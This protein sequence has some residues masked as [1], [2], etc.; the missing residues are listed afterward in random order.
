MVRD[1][2]LGG[3]EANYPLQEGNRVL[4]SLAQRQALRALLAFSALHEQI[5][6]RSAFETGPDGDLFQTERFVLGEVLQL[7]CD[8]AQ[9]ITGAEGVLIALFEGSEIRIHAV[10]GL[11]LVDR[12]VPLVTESA[13]LQECL[14]SR[15]ILRC[16]DC[17]ADDRTE[18]DMCRLVGARSAVL[19][20]LRGQAA[21]VGVLQA[22]ARGPFAFSDDD[23]RCFDLFGELVLSALRPE[24][25][26]RRLNW[27]TDVASQLLTQ[28]TV[29]LEPEVVEPE[30]AAS[31]TQSAVAEPELTE[32]APQAATVISGLE[33]EVPDLA[34]IPPDLGA[35]LPEPV[36]ESQPSAIDTE[37]AVVEQEALVRED[38][39]QPECALVVE[40]PGIG[41]VDSEAEPADDFVPSFA[42]VGEL[43]ARTEIKLEPDE[44]ALFASVPSFAVHDQGRPWLR[45]ALVVVVVAGLFAAGA[46]WGIQTHAKAIVDAALPEKTAVETPTTTPTTAT[47]AAVVSDHLLDPVKFDSPAPLPAPA[48]EESLATFPKV[49]GVRHWTSAVGSTVAI[50]ME[51][52]VPYEV[53]RLSSPARIYFD[54]HDTALTPELVARTIDVGDSS[55][56]RVRVAQPVAG[57][58]RVVLDTKAGSDF[59]VSMEENPYRLIVQLR[60]SER[61]PVRT[62]LAAAPTRSPAK[63]AALSPVPPR[64]QVKPAAFRIV[65]DAGHGGWDL[66][67][68]GR[69]GLLEKDLVLDVTERLGRLL[70]GRLGADVVFT[71]TTDTYLPLEQRAEVANQTRADLFVSV[72]ANY[73][74]TTSAR[75]VETYYTNFFSPPESREIEARENE[76]SPKPVT[77]SLSSAELHEKVQESRVLA[78]SVQRSLYSTL[79]AKSPGIRNRGVKD[80]AF[81]VLTGTTMPA[82][83]TEISFVSSPTDERNLQNEAHRQQ[84]AEALYKGIAQYEAGI[85]KKV[86]VAQVRTASAQR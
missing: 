16:D 51:D 15:R 40:S 52:Q 63:E 69:Q 21:A 43:A 46:W 2:A 48:S 34:V 55:L 70:R 18:L 32:I 10:S 1:S 74:S 38:T 71:R 68:V 62:E 22:F 17:L 84:I 50:D 42:L 13:F 80:S 56:A 33:V 81:V 60:G 53:H 54:L 6:R 11:L 14:E 12:S 72:H 23:V 66:G 67:T 65:L 78:S 57:V 76:T 61:A 83:L 5:R 73:S 3:A 49:T 82:I 47:P 31:I 45:I 26:D 64:P 24:D 8:R 9:S 41:P 86:K 79:A 29:I 77:V 30:P 75:G 44:S 39:S 19:V 59:S 36:L 28:K 37:P 58:T 7:I 4:E 27:L 35:I 20:P 85:A 25:E